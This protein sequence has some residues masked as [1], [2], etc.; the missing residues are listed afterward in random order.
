M[1]KLTGSDASLLQAGSIITKTQ[2]REL[3]PAA[4]A[5]HPAKTV[6]EKY[7]FYPTR[8]IIDALLGENWAVI[9]AKTAGTRSNAPAEYRRHS[10]AFADRDI[11]KNRSHYS[12]I[13]RILLTNSHDGNAACRMYAG[14]WRFVCSNGMVI[15]DGVV[16]SVRIAH[17]HR[18]IEEVVEAAQA[19]R[20]HTERIGEHVQAF[21]KRVL[22][23]AE[24]R[25]FAK[26][27]IVLRQPQ[28]SESV[29]A[30][31]DILAVKRV[32]DE[33]NTL[34]SVFNR[35]QEHLL[36]GGF[37]IYQHTPKGWIERTARPIKGIDQTRELNTQLWDL[38]ETF[39]LN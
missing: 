26:W 39:S 32:D 13:P 17:T 35:V 38:A 21:K 20:E 19:L 12:E 9:E 15:S 6:S 10:L 7:H 5:K 23:D 22:T 27:S 4:L 29:I 30:P 24:I 11:L 33:G 25:E 37:P 34:W 8:Q 16:Q 14:L 1:Q 3:A 31:Q 28:R 18:T 2:L 36:Q